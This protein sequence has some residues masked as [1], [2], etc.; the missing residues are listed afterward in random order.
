MFHAGGRM[1]GRA[2]MTKLIVAF[3]NFVN[4]TKPSQLMQYREVK[5]VAQ[6]MSQSTCS[7][8]I[9]CSLRLSKTLLRSKF[10]H[11]MAVSGI[12]IA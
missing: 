9:T 7:L 6:I 3:R 2:D 12:T 8:K 4:V 1:N 11:S 5:A 10:S